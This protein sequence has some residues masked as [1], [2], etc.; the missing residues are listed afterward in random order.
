M[1]DPQTATRIA[2][3]LI[4]AHLDPRFGEGVW[5][6]GFDRATR[7]AG[8]CNFTDRRITISRYLTAKS[9]DD[10]TTQ[11]LLHE[12]AHAL[13]GPRAGHGPSWKQIAA[14]LGYRGGRTHTGEIAHERAPWRG[15]C[16]AGHEH[17]RFRTPTREMSCG[18]CARGY[19]AAHAIA[20]KRR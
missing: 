2:E 19:S 9:D 10:E 13:A 12:I 20:W 1:T 17:F 8:L 18:M 16:P 15:E 7:R 3:A 5:T 4:R 11:I 6:F 14:E